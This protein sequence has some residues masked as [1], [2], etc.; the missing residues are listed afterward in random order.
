MKAAVN[1]I[2]IFEKFASKGLSGKIETK[3]FSGLLKLTKP[4]AKVIDDNL[5]LA[6][7]ESSDQWRKN[8]RIKI[9]E[10]LALTMT[11]TLVLQHDPKQ[12]LQWIKKVHN[13]EI[14]RSTLDRNKG[15]I[16]LTA[17]F[18]SWELLGVWYAQKAIEN[19]FRLRIVYQPAHDQDMAAYIRQTRERGGIIAFDKDI[20]VQKYIKM[21]KSGAHIAILNDIAGT[22]KMMA[23]FMGHDAT[24]TP[25][26]A[27][28]AMFSG[29]PMIPVCIFRKAPFNHE[30]EFFPPVKI[31][32]K[33]L[34]ISNEDRVK[35]IVLEC[36]KTIE[37]FIRR[38]P[39]QWFWLHKR[40]R[41]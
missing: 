38:Q 20:S 9:Y 2:K 16:L 33:S 15:V 41:P 18:G 29:V 3:I 12:A 7:P 17:H 22:G 32:E 19:D 6:Y 25:G 31:P 21:L 23:P 5:K 10:H 35:A 26:P 36:N 8:L 24:N 28:L 39:E 4:R 40:W 11:E 14:F 37:S 30:V 1:V 13:E 27:I 34:K